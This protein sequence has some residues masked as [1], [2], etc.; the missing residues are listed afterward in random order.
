MDM[1]T[2]SIFSEDLPPDSSRD[3]LVSALAASKAPETR[4]AYRTAWTFWTDWAS[5]H[6]Y[7]V[8][9]T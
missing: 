7:P 6:G 1:P 8:L 5:D 3:P 2:V 9:P 4:R